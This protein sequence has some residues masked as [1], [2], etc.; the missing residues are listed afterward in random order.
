MGFMPHAEDFWLLQVQGL[1]MYLLHLLPIC[2][3]GF[4]MRSSYPSSPQ[5]TQTVATNPH[6][7]SEEAEVTTNRHNYS[8]PPVI[9]PHISNCWA[10]QI[11]HGLR[12][13]MDGWAGDITP[14]F[15]NIKIPYQSVLIIILPG[16]HTGF[17]APFGQT[18]WHSRGS[19]AALVRAVSSSP[20]PWGDAGGAWGLPRAPKATA[21]TAENSNLLPWQEMNPSL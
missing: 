4:Q 10:K 19:F 18:L 3:T 11:C 20:T 1:L 13:H 12:I 2:H 21:L 5:H 17:C 8:E 7:R 16:L 14:A 9:K 15:K 6:Q